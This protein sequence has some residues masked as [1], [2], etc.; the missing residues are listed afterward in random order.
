MIGNQYLRRLV[1]TYSRVMLDEY[2]ID[3]IAEKAA[4]LTPEE[5]GI[6]KADLSKATSVVVQSFEA[7]GIDINSMSSEEL[8][9]HLLTLYENLGGGF[10]VMGAKAHEDTAVALAT[11]LEVMEHNRSRYRHGYDKSNR[12][13]SSG[14]PFKKVSK[15]MTMIVIFLESLPSLKLNAAEVTSYI[16]NNPTAIE[17][18]IE[19]T[20]TEDITP[21]DSIIKYR[22]DVRPEKSLIETIRP[23]L[24]QIKKA[25][26]NSLYITY[27]QF[28]DAGALTPLPIGDTLEPS[29]RIALRLYKS[30]KIIY[31]NFTGKGAVKFDILLSDEKTKMA[32]QYIVFAA[33]AHNILGQLDYTLHGL[34]PD[35]I[36]ELRQEIRTGQYLSLIHISEPTRH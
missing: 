23:A 1:R 4:T 15:A 9:E 7:A 28:T 12:S 3:E 32:T 33:M 24:E 6:K 29:T 36:T 2:Q 31:N 11:E 17:R 26:H 10:G 20:V 14:N 8:M 16:A 19:K 35:E 22:K 18:I 27:N 5:V 30:A 13:F 34:S 21:K 25:G